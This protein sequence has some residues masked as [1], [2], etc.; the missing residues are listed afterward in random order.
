MVSAWA[1]IN[2]PPDCTSPVYVYNLKCTTISN[3]AVVSVQYAQLA[4]LLSAE[5]EL[6]ISV[7]LHL[8]I[9]DGKPSES[10]RG[11]QHF[12]TDL[13]NRPVGSQR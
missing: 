13:C 9:F 3:T 6:V 2:L 4:R 11:S 1:R 7:H 8:Q 12:L 10:V 5:L